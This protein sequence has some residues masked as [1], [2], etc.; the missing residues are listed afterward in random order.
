MKRF[1][2]CRARAAP[3][4]IHHFLEFLLQ[5]HE[6]F[7]DLRLPEGRL[8]RFENRIKNEQNQVHPIT[9]ECS[10]QSP[11]LSLDTL[12]LDDFKRIVPLKGGPVQL[13]V[14]CIDS[15]FMGPSKRTKADIVSDGIWVTLNDTV[16][17]GGPVGLY[18]S[19]VFGVPIEHELH[20]LLGKYMQ[21]IYN[22]VSYFWPSITSS[23][24]PRVIYHGTAKE[25]TSSILK[26][27][28]QSSFGML[29][30]AIY[31]SHFWK[32]H[33]Y[34]TMAQ[35]YSKRNGTVLRV[36]AFW[37]TT[38]FRSIHSEPCKCTLCFGPSK[39]FIKNSKQYYIAAQCDHREIWKLL[40]DSVQVWPSVG[41]EGT[42]KNEEFACSNSNLLLID[43]FGYASCATEVYE[44]LNRSHTIH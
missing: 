12:V 8:K 21:D 37:T 19:A 35:D 10:L 26:T 16:P 13:E 2:Y 7:Q 32:A 18:K 3:D 44:P 30:N 5:W 14:C 33:R 38:T 39:P 40:G 34:A 20:M 11:D 25:H 15:M 17:K 22:Q 9:I 23:C 24:E 42:I 4:G 31:F 1:F 43:S 29:G 27:G 36:Y 6:V 28:F 41:L